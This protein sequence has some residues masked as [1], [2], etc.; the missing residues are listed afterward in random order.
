MKMNVETRDY[1]EFEPRYGRIAPDVV[2]RLQALKRTGW[3]RRGVE[4]AESVQEHTIACRN[5]VITLRNFLTEFS[6]QDI[7]EI[8]DMLE[9]HDWPESDPGVGDIVITQAGGDI[10]KIEKF[11]AELMAINRICETLNTHGKRI[12]QLWV[13]FEQGQDSTSLFARQV[14]KLQAIERALEYE[15][16]GGNSVLT[17]EFIDSDGENI[18]HPVLI[19]R[20][21][22]LKQQLADLHK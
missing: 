5:L 11:Q 18:T 8:L 10:K 12:F 22:N 9:V 13:L 20:L 7:L 4:N 1:N 19:K 21:Q 2:L 17:Q 16:T 6:D 3:I 15:R 14:D